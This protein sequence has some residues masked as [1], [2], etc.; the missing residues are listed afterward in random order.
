MIC[1]VGHEFIVIRSDV[2]KSLSLHVSGVFNRLLPAFQ[3][4]VGLG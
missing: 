3:V 2:G 4:H 1:A